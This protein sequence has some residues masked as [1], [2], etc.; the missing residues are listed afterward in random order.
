MNNKLSFFLNSLPEIFTLRLLTCPPLVQLFSPRKVSPCRSKE[1]VVCTKCCSFTFPHICS[2]IKSP[3]ILSEALPFHTSY[4]FQ[5]CLLDGEY[6][7]IRAVS[8]S[9]E[10]FCSRRNWETDWFS[11][12]GLVGREGRLCSLDQCSCWLTLL[13]IQQ[14]HSVSL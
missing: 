11:T 9:R 3:R 8:L 2:T 6:L 14:I 7:S 1:S 10:S 4:Q 13:S 12:P 5:P